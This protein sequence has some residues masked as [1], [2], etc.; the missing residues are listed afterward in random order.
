MARQ[1]LPRIFCLA[2]G[3]PAEP[4]GRPGGLGLTYADNACHIGSEPE[5]VND[6]QQRLKRALAIFNLETHEETEAGLLR[7]PLGVRVD[8]S[9]GCVRP[10]AGRLW[11]LDGA[12]SQIRA[13]V[14]ISGRELVR[15][16]GGGGTWALFSGLGLQI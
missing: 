16:D 6:R 12:L 4:M 1:A 14:W 13:N 5:S 15:L 10:T 7:K 8:G 9:E 2:D 11:R 3:R